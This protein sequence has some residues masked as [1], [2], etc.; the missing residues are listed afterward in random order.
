MKVIHLNG[1]TPLENESYRQQI[2]VNLCEAM[3]T[4]LEL[5]RASNLALRGAQSEADGA[6]FERW[7]KV[8]ER[9]AYP[10]KYEGAMRRLWEDAAVQECVARGAEVNLGEK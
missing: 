6:L 7:P 2:W 4:C 3:A 9:E 8:M 10:R 1:F 5:A